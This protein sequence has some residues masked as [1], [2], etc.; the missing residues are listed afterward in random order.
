MDTFVD[1][2]WYYLRFC[3]PDVSDVPFRAEEVARWMPV[4]QYIGGAEH[5]V[6][7]LMYARFF[8]KAV[9]VLGIAPKE[10]REPFQR[11]FTQGMF[12]L[13]GAKRSKSKGNLVAPEQI[14]DSLGA[15]ALRLAHLAVKPP[16]DDVDWE[17][18][19]LEGCSRFLHR[20][21]RLAVP[22]T[23][24]AV[25]ARSGERTAADEAITKAMHRLID[26]ITNDFDRWSYNVA[27][28]KYMAFVNDLYRYVQSD[29]GAHAEVLATAVD[30]LLQVLAPACPHITAELWTRRHTGSAEPEH[31]H[32][33]SWPAAD[34]AQLVEDAVTLV[35]QVNGKVRDRIEVAS[36]ADEATCLAAAL[37]SDKVRA[38]LDG[39]EPRKVI[40]RPPKLD[41][42]VV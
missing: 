34:P 28:A 30:T 4:D 14:I 37:A 27:V 16:E 35:V 3:D 1:S 29:D 12:G 41:N 6:L 7:H 36:D 21:W 10:L 2:S 8:T 9:S 25:A 24:L 40:V 39:A 13:V 32:E 17:D 20:V 19:G 26:D 42:Q 5:A 33:T 22:G 38:Q 18:V 23:D 11:L 31:V 15:D